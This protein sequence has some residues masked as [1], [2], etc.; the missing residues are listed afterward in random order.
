MIKIQNF[1]KHQKKNIIDII[2]LILLFGI[3][4]SSFYVLKAKI[5]PTIEQERMEF[6]NIIL[7]DSRNPQLSAWIA[8]GTKICG[9]PGEQNE[10][11]IISDQM[12][13]A[14]L[15]WT[16][17]R[18]GSDIYTQRV[19]A[20]GKVQWIDNGTAIC[21]KQYS[22]NKVALASDGL[23]GAIIVWEDA[24]T[25][26]NSVDIYAQR[27]NSTGSVQWTL[28]GTAIV[29]LTYLQ[30]RPKV[31]SDGMGGAIIVWEDF[32]SGS[33]YDL[34]AQRI[35]STGSV[36][37]TLNGIA[38]CDAANSQLNLELLADGSG[39]VFIVWQDYRYSNYDIY[40]Q[41]INSTG[42]PQW[43]NNGVVICNASYW[44]QWPQLISDGTGG[45]II[46]WEDYRNGTTCDVYAQKI[47]S[48]GNVQWVEN[49]TI[50][51]NQNGAQGAPVI[52]SDNAGGAIIVWQDYRYGT[53]DLFAQHVN[54]SG[55]SQWDANGTAVCIFPGYQSEVKIVSDINGCAYVVWED[56]RYGSSNMD[57]YA[58][59]IDSDGS[60]AW[61]VSGIAICS[62]SLEQRYPS[63]ASDGMG[64]LFIAWNDLRESG[65]Y[66]IYAHRIKGKMQWINNGSI[67]CNMIDDQRDPRL[68]SDGVGGA[69]ITWSDA[70]VGGINA[71]IYAQRVNFA[72][73]QQ[74]KS[75]GTLICQLPYGQLTPQI[76]SDG[77]GGAIIA[78]YD[79]RT[80]IKADIYT[81]RI[82]ALGVTQWTTNGISICNETATNIAM[83]S[84][85]EGGAII[86][87]QD[88]RIDSKYD[89]KAQKVNSKGITQ[90]TVNGTD[91]CITEDEQTEPNLI[92]D[93]AGGAIIT[94][95]D[96]RGPKF[97][98]YAQRINSTGAVKWA[99][100]G[101]PI[102][103]ASED[104][105]L[106]ELT[107]AGADG[108]II[109]WYDNRSQT[110]TCDIYAQ[111]VN[112]TGN[113]KWIS[114]G[115]AVCTSQFKQIN[116][117]IVGDGQEGA[118]IT[119]EDYR[120]DGTNWN[121]D[122]YVQKIISSGQIQWNANGTA[123]CT[124]WNHQKSPNLI[125]DQDGNV[126][127]I[128]LDRRIDGT[129]Y[130]IY[131]QSINSSSIAR[132]M[133]NGIPICTVGETQYAVDIASDQT[134]G[135]FL[136]WYD[137][138]ILGT[139]IYA[140]RFNPRPDIKIISPIANDSFLDVVPSFVIRTKDGNDIDSLWYTLNSNS[141]KFF[142]T[143][144]GSID[145]NAWATLIDGYVN[146]TFYANDTIEN[147]NFE[148]ITVIKQTTP[149]SG[150][151]D[152][153]GGK[154][155]DTG[156]DSAGVI[157]PPFDSIFIIILIIGAILGA[158]II[159]GIAV[160]II[161][162]KR[163]TPKPTEPSKI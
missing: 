109:T 80:F 67:I 79:Y 56:D 37:W 20:A 14:I 135:V 11:K 39:G 107:G 93:G 55:L 10:V 123:V 148:L 22:Q 68:I 16:D 51:C 144:N 89:I 90:W 52:A 69:I 41:W 120:I 133:L 102:C 66:N 96:K 106:P 60:I 146:I 65:N 54:S 24:R 162:R 35:N 2:F 53:D 75:N 119:W 72:G 83:I 6:E 5:F 118:I 82:N 32:R 110:T 31:I 147:L 100:N 154:D 139:S 160:V 151:D 46:T 158:I 113:A 161:K 44:Q 111:K 121:G 117:K 112:S 62:A 34:Y 156:D 101:V 92:S 157:P 142:F 99:S 12:G 50:I 19:N 131:G 15:V 95:Q 47:S 145:I 159:V 38:V 17:S 57:I 25:P 74:W 125:S 36:Q 137:S 63:I 88:N 115:I 128:W 103:S 73:I 122:I 59:K 108:A 40:A 77:L 98:I 163:S 58:Q 136:T 78:W 3:G 86:A 42:V 134:G 85:G 8:N 21:T 94:W 114:N 28:N 138:R 1:F 71:D 87:W 23:G 116:P 13:G 149:S 129:N 30:D 105:M 141:T 33:H 64:G 124:A 26:A 140:S 130:N 155:D 61:S 29:T 143:S 153:D 4:F 84:D 91:I 132:E 97:D 7:E 150:D 152:D 126:I 9:A 127:I 81:Q 43:K 49:G 76:V 70:R 104:Q 48:T 27:V 18:S 45:A